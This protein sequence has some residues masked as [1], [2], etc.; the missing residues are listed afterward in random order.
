MM[1]KQIIE[2]GIQLKKGIDFSGGNDF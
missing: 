2:M 1:F